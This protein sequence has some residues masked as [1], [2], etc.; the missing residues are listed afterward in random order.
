MLWDSTNVTVNVITATNQVVHASITK[1]N[2]NKWILSATYGS[3]NND[4]RDHMWDNFS[5]VDSSSDA[6]WMVVG[7]FNDFFSTF[8]RRSNARDTSGSNQCRAN[9]FNDNLDRCRLMDLGSYGQMMTW[10]NG[11][12]GLANT[13]VRLDHALA[14]ANWCELF[15]EAIVRVLPRTYSDHH[16]LLVLTDGMIPPPILNCNF[17]M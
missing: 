6:P 2:Y 11:R 4:Y 8:E 3:P 5:H 15:P 13:L 1:A 17:I 14:N 9:K 7:D 16:P 10:T 12:F